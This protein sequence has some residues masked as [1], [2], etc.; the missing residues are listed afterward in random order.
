[1]Y[2]EGLTRLVAANVTLPGLRAGDPAR[3]AVEG[4]PGRLAF[5]LIGRRSYKNRDDDARSVA[6]QD[7]LAALEQGRT[8]LG[9]RL[10]LTPTQR[11]AVVADSAGDRIDAVLCLL[12][13]GWAAGQPGCGVPEDVDPVEGWI[14]GP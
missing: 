7:L 11:D 3:V 9:L 6:R 4:Y 12:L 10:R 8:R 5:E 13:A 14:V 2:F 1:M